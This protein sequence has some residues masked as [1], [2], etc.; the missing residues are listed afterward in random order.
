[1]GRGFPP[2]PEY[3]TRMPL[4][5]WADP[6]PPFVASCRPP[7]VPLKP[8]PDPAPAGH[9]AAIVAAIRERLTC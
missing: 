2:E 9:L 7:R 4:P 8:I 1:M 6:R 5:A 3:L